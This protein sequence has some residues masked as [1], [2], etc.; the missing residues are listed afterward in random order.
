[1]CRHRFVFARCPIV[2]RYSLERRDKRES[3]LAIGC[4]LPLRSNHV[5]DRKRSRDQE[6]ACR[7]KCCPWRTAGHPSNA[8]SPKR[9]WA[10]LFVTPNVQSLQA[11]L[12]YA[13]SEARERGYD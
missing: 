10:H 4:L 7:C 6:N 5:L 12:G 1:M 9:K 8:G 3:I 2:L 11:H 13:A